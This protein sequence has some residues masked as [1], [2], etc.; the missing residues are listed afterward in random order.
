MFIDKNLLYGKQLFILIV[1][2]DLYLILVQKCVE[3]LLYN[4]IRHLLLNNNNKRHMKHLKKKDT[5]CLV[6]LI[7]RKKNS[8]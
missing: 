2:N 8:Q 7:L 4:M 5:K 1:N 6:I 3:G